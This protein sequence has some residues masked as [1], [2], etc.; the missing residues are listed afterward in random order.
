MA[1]KPL[2]L[3]VLAL[4]LVMATSAAWAVNCSCISVTG[5]FF[6]P[7][8]GATTLCAKVSPPSIWQ[9]QFKGV[10]PYCLE[11]KAG[12]LYTNTVGQICA[13]TV[14]PQGVYKVKAYTQ[15][16]NSLQVNGCRK[17]D[18]V[19][20]SVFNPGTTSCPFC[21]AQGGGALRLFTYDVPP[22]VRTSLAPR[23][24]TFAYIFK[25][26]P[27]Q[28]LGVWY[29]DNDNPYGPLSFSARSYTHLFFDKRQV[30]GTDY[31]VVEAYGTGCLK[32]ASVAVSV[33]CDPCDDDPYGDCWRNCDPVRYYIYADDYPG[34]S[35]FRIKLWDFAGNLI[36]QSALDGEW[37]ETTVY[38]GKNVIQECL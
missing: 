6:N 27:P 5:N 11:F 7:K 13:K 9:V 1:R 17:S 29:F 22:N 28:N 34:D 18:P 3:V 21:G 37:P 4:T 2:Y 15:A 38:N 26:N 23:Q 24:A 16:N 35:S 25:L 33:Q 10:T 14:W 20:V 19:A 32:I 36:Y 12:P 8:P 30:N 31:N